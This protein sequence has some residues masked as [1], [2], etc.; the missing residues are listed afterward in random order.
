MLKGFNKI[1]KELEN[2]ENKREDAIKNSRNIIRLSKLIIYSVHRDNF[3]KA[4]EQVEDINKKIKELEK[5]PY[6]T[7]I[8]DVAFQ[9]YVEAICYY[10]FVKNDKLPS[11]EELNVDVSSYLMG[12]CDLTGEL[13]RKA[14]RDIIKRKYEEVIKIRDFVDDLHGQ[15][16]DFDLRNNDLRRKSDSIKW[17][18]KKLEDLALEVKTKER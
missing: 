11:F 9:E 1:K 13:V 7:S 6:E 10:E 5:N 15:F 3:K 16:L 2:L 8:V 18:L 17:N 4:R 14:V 12:L